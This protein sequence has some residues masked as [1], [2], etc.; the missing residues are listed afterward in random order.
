[1]KHDI[2]A[3]QSGD[4]DALREIFRNTRKLRAEIIRKVAGEAMIEKFTWE[5]LDQV[6][7]VGVMEAVKRFDPNH[8]AGKP[9][10]TVLSYRIRQEVVQYIAAN[11]GALSMPDTAYR[12]GSKI[13]KMVEDEEIWRR[14]DSELEASTGERSAGA[15][16]RARLQPVSIMKPS[17]EWEID[18][19][20]HEDEYEDE[21]EDTAALRMVAELTAEPDPAVRR[22]RA[23]SWAHEMGYPTEVAARLIE[24]VEDQHAIGD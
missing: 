11:S 3:A 12:K 13:D 15:I 6:A 5:E 19:L 17:G 8:P 1:M 20:G 16:V 4:V 14:S 9:F 21:N 22:L 2:D 10:E 23:L 18:E 7:S 24:V